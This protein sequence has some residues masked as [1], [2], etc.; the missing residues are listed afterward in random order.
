MWRKMNQPAAFL[1]RDGTII[2]DKHYLKDPNEVEFLG[3]VIPALKKLRDN[4]YKII[5]ITN[6]SGVS[7]GMFSYESIALVHS[8]LIEMLAE[9][10]IEILDFGICPHQ[11]S[12]H[13]EC[14]KPSPKLINDLMEKHNIDKNKSFMCGDKDSDYQAGIN[15][16]IKSYLLENDD[17]EAIVNN[18]LAII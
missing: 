11:P 6:Q 7:R 5:I 8:R 9:F 15:A 4:G 10:E 13:C 17:L 16:K 3:T 12:D 18:H 14:R 2:K 1:D